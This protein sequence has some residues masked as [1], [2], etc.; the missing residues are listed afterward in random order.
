[1][2][3]LRDGDTDSLIVK[4]K[5]THASKVKEE[6]GHYFPLQAVAWPVLAKW[7]VNICNGCLGRKLP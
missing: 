1:M 7:G 5:I 4:A 3:R 2:R 6:F